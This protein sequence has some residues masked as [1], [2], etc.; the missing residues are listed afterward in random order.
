MRAVI[1]N[2][3]GRVIATATAR[4]FLSP[5]G[6]GTEVLYRVLRGGQWQHA[7]SRWTYAMSPADLADDLDRHRRVTGRA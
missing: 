2:E 3:T 1:Q 6:P 5:Y 4:A 7:S